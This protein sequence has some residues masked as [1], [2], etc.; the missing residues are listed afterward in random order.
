MTDTPKRDY[1]VAIIGSGFGGTMTGIP[2]AQA[3]TERNQ[4]KPPDRIF[5]YS[6]WPQGGDNPTRKKYFDRGRHAIG[7][8]VL[9]AL[10]AG[11]SLPLRNDLEPTL[12]KQVLD[13]AVNTGLSNIVA[14]TARLEPHWD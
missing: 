2:L 13:A 12:K 4:G 9:S 10:K 6:R 7:Y 3:F 1:T 5:D 11:N 8:S 14:R